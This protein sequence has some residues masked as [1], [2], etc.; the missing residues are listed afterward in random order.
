[1]LCNHKKYSISWEEKITATHKTNLTIT[2]SNK[3]LLF[4]VLVHPT[5]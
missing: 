2:L 5:H 1:M 3:L 4:T